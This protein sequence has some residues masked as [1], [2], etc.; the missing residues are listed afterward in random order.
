MKTFFLTTVLLLGVFFGMQYASDGIQSMQGLNNNDKTVNEQDIEASS[1]QKL[2]NEN[3]DLQKKYE[4]LE[5]L[6]AFNFFSSVGTLLSDGLHFVMK[7]IIA[8][9]ISAIDSLIQVE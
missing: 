1:N 3:D 9:A 8:I 7:E 2:G 5:D 4:Q 6:K